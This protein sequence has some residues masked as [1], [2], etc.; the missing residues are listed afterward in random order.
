MSLEDNYLHKGMR[1]RLVEELKSKGIKDKAVLDAIMIVPR[2]VFFDNIFEKD[3]YD[4][5]A[6]PIGEGQTIS[7]PY[8]VAFQSQLLDIKKDD[9][10]LEI[11]TG[12]GYQSSVLLE[13]GAKLY[14]IERHKPLHNKAVK[15]IAKLGYHK[16]QFYV[17]DGT[18]GMSAYAPYDGIIVTAGAPLVPSD[19]VKQLK[20]G[21]RLIIPVGDDSKQ[22][23]IRLTKVGEKEIQKEEFG[24]FSFVP[25]IGERGW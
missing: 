3:A 1:R 25:L 20:I 8:T 11:G 19:L 12:S 21:G 10:I 7:Q 23:M 6:F 22:K 18:K 9:K 15:Q 17:G 14:S 24:V 13:M 5:K 2:H 16:G 4:D